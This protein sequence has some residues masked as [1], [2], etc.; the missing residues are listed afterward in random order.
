MHIQVVMVTPTKSF[1]R[2]FCS[3]KI[4]NF[5]KL[6]YSFLEQLYLARLLKD[7]DHCALRVTREQNKTQFYVGYCLWNDA[8]NTWFCEAWNNSFLPTKRWVTVDTPRIKPIRA[9]W[10]I[11]WQHTFRM[12]QNI[13]S[14]FDSLLACKST[15]L[16]SL[17]N[18]Q[19]TLINFLK[20]SS[21][22]ALIKDL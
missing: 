21:L 7:F 20:K 14:K 9:Y 16:R 18:V 4:I 1:L 5:F 3:M 8:W 6:V 11:F 15:T 17:I 2:A 10:T 22:Y 19:S 12:Q 13:F